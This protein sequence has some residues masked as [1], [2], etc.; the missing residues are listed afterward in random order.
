MMKAV[1]PVLAG[2]IAKR[3]IKKTALAQGAGMSDRVLR[4]KMAGK[5]PF[6]LP[7]ALAIKNRFF[8][9]FGVEALF[10]KDE[11]A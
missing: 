1:Y 8:P 7:E 3:G 9:D 6:S 11:T 4:N 2:E 10:K 5:T